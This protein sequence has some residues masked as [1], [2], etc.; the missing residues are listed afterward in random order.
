MKRLILVSSLAFAAAV[1][2]AQAPAPAE[3]RAALSPVLLEHF[4]KRIYEWDRGAPAG[5]AGG[6]STMAEIEF[7]TKTRPQL[8]KAGTAAFPLA[9]RV[10]E[11][12]VTSQ[13]NLYSFAFIIM[14]MTPAPAESQLAELTRLAGS[15]TSAERVVAFAQLA[16]TSAPEALE[17]LSNAVR[18]SDLPLRLMATVAL[19]YMGRA[20]PTEVPL[21]VA[22]N[23]KDSDKAVRTAAVNALRLIGGPAQSVAPQLIDYLRTKDNPYMAT[24]ALRA[25][26]IELLLP[27]KADV[28][29]IVGDS[30]LTAVQK[31][32][33]VDLLMKIE[34]S[35]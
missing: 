2:V 27:A 9:P 12:M 3:P 18:A 31:Q 1:A 23:L 30:R 6:S 29:A 22:P 7:I 21:L 15:G 5:R 10:A 13:K 32:D 28:E 33:A 4:Y 8:Y 16:R 19:G 24:A 14:G 25:F 26:P 35:R 17:L 20:F 34:T 11:L